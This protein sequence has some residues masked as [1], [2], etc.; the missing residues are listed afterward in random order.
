MTSAVALSLKPYEA[1]RRYIKNELNAQGVYFVFLEDDINPEAL[2]VMA[3]FR[4][5]KINRRFV[6]TERFP[7]REEWA[8]LT[9]ANI[10]RE[11]ERA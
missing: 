3:D 4:D 7:L 1:D 11:R 10:L 6:H 5:G 9:I 8:D 2:S